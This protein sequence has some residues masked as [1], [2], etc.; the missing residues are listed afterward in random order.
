MEET[1]IQQLDSRHILTVY[2]T[3]LQFQS[4]IIR[5]LKKIKSYDYIISVLV[6]I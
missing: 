4:F 3:H 5:F 2:I 6:N 1:Y